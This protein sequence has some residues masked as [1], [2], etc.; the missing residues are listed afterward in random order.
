MRILH[1]ADWHLG[2]RLEGRGRHDEQVA[3]MDEICAIADEEHVDVVLVAGDVF[4]TYNPPAES[5]ALFYR[6]MTRLA[7]GGQRSVVVI[8]GN[9]DS[10]DRL[11]ASDPYARALGITTL[12]YPKDTPALYDG[13]TDRAACVEAAPSFVR[14]RVPRQ[15]CYLWVLALPYP[16]EARLRELL[17]ADINND[18]QATIDYNQRVQSFLKERAQSFVPGEANIVASHLFVRGGG[19]SDSERDVS[20]GGAYAVDAAS[21]PDTAGY[22]ALGH[23]HRAQ[24]MHSATGAPVRYS[25]SI[26]QYSFSEAEQTKSVTIV[27]ITS[28]GTQHRVVPISAGRRLFKWEAHGLDELERRL[29]DAMTNEW[30]WITLH[31][32]APLPP[33]YRRNVMA[34]HPQI[35]ECITH[36]HRTDDPHEERTSVDALPLDEQFRRFVRDKYNEPCADDVMKLFLELAATQRDDT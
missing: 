18:E 34:R 12:G 30:H 4:D 35:F 1:T 16:S 19:M 13:G 24:E 33:D 2:R 11:I 29:Q 5:E 8:A 36:Y 7:N 26:L 14:L 20:V 27:E 9:H 31:L 25:G 23:L 17:T 3:A 22:I 10:P 6:T 15:S 32:D 21:F 28:G